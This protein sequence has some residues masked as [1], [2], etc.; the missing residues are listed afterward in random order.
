MTLRV[1][2]KASRGMDFLKEWV[3]SGLFNGGRVVLR[4]ATFRRDP[5]YRDGQEPALFVDFFQVDE[6]ETL[7]QQRI[8]I[9]NG[10]EEQQ[11]GTRIERADGGKPIINDNTA[12]GKFITSLL[13]D[14]DAVKAIEA[15]WAAGDK[16]T[17]QDA[18][19]WDGLDVE[20]EQKSRDFKTRDGEDATQRWYDVTKFHGYEG[21][22]SNGASAT[23]SPAP[24]KKAAPAKAAAKKSSPK[25]AAASTGPAAAAPEPTPADTF[26]PDQSVLDAIR[27]QA[28]V[29]NDFEEFVVNCY[30][31]VAEVGEREEYQALVD[32]T[33][34]VE[35]SIWRQA[36]EA[37]EAAQ[38]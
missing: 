30:T 38:G 34:N 21:S 32:D 20:L 15:R 11:E 2:Q 7:E 13:G 37:Y 33:E 31:N 18:A 24:A 5:G 35:G 1:Q 23:A 28:D 14:T 4:S 12:A 16:V 26:T 29:S 19:F 8:G 10:W 3:G 9:G 6:Q 27:A 25:K 17:P 36:V 22:G